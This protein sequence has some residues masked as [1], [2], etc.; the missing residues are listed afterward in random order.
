VVPV[1]KSQAATPHLV[2]RA[3]VMT[4][5]FDAHVKATVHGYVI[6]AKAASVDNALALHQKK[7]SAVYCCDGCDVTANAT[8]DVGLAAASSKELCIHV[9]QAQP[10]PSTSEQQRRTIYDGTLPFHDAHL[11]LDLPI[12]LSQ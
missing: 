9:N 2:K 4:K 10:T 11:E 8:T 5:Q 1:N 12:H 6:F 7:S 3:A